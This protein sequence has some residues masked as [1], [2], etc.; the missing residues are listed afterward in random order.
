MVHG[1]KKNP[2]YNFVD[3]LNFAIKL[4]NGINQDE[5]FGFD[6]QPLNSSAMN[7]GSKNVRVDRFDDNDFNG[8]Q[9]LS[10]GA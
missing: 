4:I 6:P 10:V 9:M 3:Y 2:Q 8:P 5:T 1:K 7:I